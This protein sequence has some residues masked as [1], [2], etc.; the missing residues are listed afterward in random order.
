M[1][2][3]RVHRPLPPESILNEER[4]LRNIVTWKTALGYD[5]M[6]APS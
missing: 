4:Y 1:Y 6:M 3:D 5:V 2:K